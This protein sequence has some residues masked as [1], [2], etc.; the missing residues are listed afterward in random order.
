MPRDCSSALRLTFSGLSSP[1]TGTFSMADRT[2]KPAAGMCRLK[3][4]HLK[5]L[6]VRAS[7]DVRA[8]ERHHQQWPQQGGSAEFTV[9][10]LE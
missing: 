10:A 7:V 2:F 3:G 5:M 4:A 6:D 1:S 9:A 8:S